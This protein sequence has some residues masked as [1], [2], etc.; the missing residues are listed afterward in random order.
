MTSHT[1]EILAEAQEYWRNG[2]VGFTEYS[3]FLRENSD[4]RHSQY[5]FS[6][7]SSGNTLELSDSDSEVEY[8]EAIGTRNTLK[9]LW[10][11]FILR[12]F[13]CQ[14]SLLMIL[15]YVI[16]FFI[17]STP[18]IPLLPKR[19]RSRTNFDSWQVDELEKVFKTTQYPDVFTREALA[20]K[21]DLLE[22]RIQVF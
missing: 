20:L 1:G 19:R 9:P 15:L 16:L 14:Q 21:L 12:E 4:L 17:T 11:V 13:S 2:H 8:Y 18:E 3:K 7:F 10:K 22:S 6:S 5:I